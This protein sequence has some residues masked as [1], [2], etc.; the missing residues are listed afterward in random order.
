[1]KTNA[2]IL[3]V[4]L[5]AVLPTA[6]AEPP[7]L[8]ARMYSTQRAWQIGDLLTVI[9][10]EQTTSSKNETLAT[11]KAATADADPTIVGSVDGGTLSRKL[12]QLDLPGYT[13]SGNS[14]F[15]G[16]GSTTSSEAFAANF[17]ARVVDVLGNGVLVI[18]GDRHVKIRK[19]TVEIAITGLIRKRDISADNTIPSSQIAD[20][21]IIYNTS[22]TVSRGTNPGWLWKVFQVINPL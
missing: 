17:S 14:D 8:A 6:A 2:I 21:Q 11:S 4:A 22:G 5:A 18:R 1:M 3:A 12:S 15:S 20:A 16:S 10:D 7:S 13:V 19:E 9:V